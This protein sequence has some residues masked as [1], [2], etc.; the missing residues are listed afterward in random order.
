[1]SYF[2]KIIADS[3]SPQGVRLTT[4]EVE[5]PHAIHKDIMTHC[6]LE[7]NFLSFRAYPPEKV[8][9]MIKSDPIIPEAFTTRAKGMEQG[10]PVQGRELLMAQSIWFEHRDHAIRTAERLLDLDIGK[11]QVNFVLQD[12]A[13]IRG[14]ITATH[15]GNFWALRADA[16]EGAKPRPE[17]EKI[18]R[19][20]KEAYVNHIP[21]DVPWNGYHLPYV[22]PDEQAAGKQSAYRGDWD[23]W[24]AVSTGRCAR[25]S[26]L[27]HDGK[28]DP[29]LDAGLHTS[30]LGNGHMSPFGH[31]AKPRMIIDRSRTPGSRLD[32]PRTQ[33]RIGYRD[34]DVERD[35]LNY[36]GKFYGWDPYRKEI[37]FEHDFGL[38]REANEQPT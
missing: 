29:Y 12:H 23:F 11:D 6:A 33:Y 7:R 4:M 16:S 35:P 22:F 3:V 34:Y 37:P 1:M 31:I 17:V 20:M 9:E 15:W 14:I 10:D 30:L 13:W 21:A 19:L 24:K 32:T 2:A 5:Y 8:I 25:I 36:G 27:T 26:Y 28:R 18:A 38:M